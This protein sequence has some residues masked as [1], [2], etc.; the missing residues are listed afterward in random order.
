VVLTGKQK[1]AIL[2]M[3][4]DTVSAVELLK[5]MDAEVV[6]EL[7]MELAS[8][9]AS[10]L[11]NNKE[12]KKV[13]QEFCN[14]LKESPSQG[15]DIGRFLNEILVSILGEERAEQI[16][17]QIKKTTVHKDIFADIRSANV[18][19]LIVALEN[20]QPPT[21][22]VVLSELNPKKSQEALSLLDEDTRLK[23]VWRMTNPDMMGFAVKQRIASIVGERLKSLK[24]G[25]VFVAKPGK[26]EENLRKLAIVLS[27]LEKDLRDQLLGE[28]IKHDEETGKMIT[29]LMITWEDILSIADRSLQESLRSVDSQKL[30]V[31]LY[32]A[33][34]E[35]AQKIRSNI[36]ERARAILDEEISLMQEPLEK[37]V[38][39]AREEVVNPLR[40]ANEEGKLRM[41]GR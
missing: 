40:E 39:D 36:S 38:L 26:R 4:L 27:G 21:I 28:I 19:E 25:E 37:E 5:G 33:D 10:G 24:G 6:Q 12:Q 18:D 15:L 7:A 1:A 14:S 30:A 23:T 32:G 17:T 34:E 20:E 11:C 31:A 2:L 16:R 35:I 22:A 3:S 41:V 8:L 13:V 29:N 9:D